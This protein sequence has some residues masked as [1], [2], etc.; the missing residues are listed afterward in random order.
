LSSAKKLL[1]LILLVMILPIVHSQSSDSVISGSTAGGT[2]DAFAGS[3]YDNDGDGVC[4]EGRDF[5]RDRNI[6]SFDTGCTIPA[7]RDFCPGTPSDETAHRSGDRAGCSD[8]Q[9][10]GFQNY[11]TLKIEKDKIRPKTVKTNWLVDQRQGIRVY[12]PITFLQNDAFLNDDEKINYRGVSVRCDSGRGVVRTEGLRDVETSDVDFSRETGGG[13]VDVSSAR[14]GVVYIEES[15][16]SVSVSDINR[17]DLNA[18]LVIRLRQQAEELVRPKDVRNYRGD[19]GIDE[20]EFECT[21]TINQ[22][23]TRIEVVDGQRVEQEGCSPIFPPETDEFLLVVPLDSVAIQAPEVFLDAGIA[24]ATAILSVTNDVKPKLRDLYGFLRNNCLRAIGIV[25][26]SK[27]FSVVPGANELADFIWF[28]PKKLQNLGIFYEGS[29]IVSGRSMCAATACPRDWCRPL[30][31][32]PGG[33]ESGSKSLADLTSTYNDKGEVVSTQPIQNSLILSTACGCVSGILAKV[34]EIEA[35]AINWRTCML[36]AKDSNEFIGECDRY[37]KEGICEFVIREVGTFDNFDLGLFS[38]FKDKGG[39][40]ETTDPLIEATQ[41]KGALDRPKGAFGDAISKGKKKSEDFAKDELEV[42][43]SSGAKGILGYKDHALAR[44]FCSLAVYKELPD[45]STLQS[46]DLNRIS[47]ESTTTSNWDI[48]EAYKGEGGRSVWGYE[49]SWMIVAGKENLRYNVYLESAG[50]ARRQLHTDVL[51]NVGDFDSDFVEITDSIEYTNLC[52]D[53]RGDARRIRCFPAGSGSQ[54]GLLE[55]F[56]FGGGINDRDKDRLPDEWE[57]RFNCDSSRTKFNTPEDERACKE[58]LSNSVDNRLDPDND[59]TDGDNTNDGSEDPDNDGINNYQEYRT[60]GHPNVASRTVDGS[61]VQSSCRAGFDDFEII[62]G[63]NIPNINSISKKFIPGETL[64][65]R[66]NNV[67]IGEG[68]TVSER[69]IKVRVDVKGPRLFS[70]D[71]FVDIPFNQASVNNNPIWNIPTGRNAPDTEVY[72]VVVQLV[73]PG[74][75]NLREDACVDSGG[76]LAEK[77]KKIIIYNPNSG[78]CID[79]DEG[80]KFN[81]AGACVDNTGVVRGDSC[82][83]NDQVNDFFCNGNNICTVRTGSCSGGNVCRN[84]A[85]VSVVAQ[86]VS[87]VSSSDGGDTTDASILDQQLAAEDEIVVEEIE[88][89]LF[90]SEL[91]DTLLVEPRELSGLLDLSSSDFVSSAVSDREVAEMEITTYLSCPTQDIV[92][93]LTKERS[94][95]VMDFIGF[96]WRGDAWYMSVLYLN[97]R[98]EALACNSRTSFGGLVSEE[99]HIRAR[100]LCSCGEPR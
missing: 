30:N 45:L 11:W 29:F 68:N 75:F 27:L 1:I 71:Q 66:L 59:N 80:V 38:R 93:F 76:V 100:E 56:G 62:G 85:C 99:A 83:G 40:G 50:G 60:N 6:N 25:F 23:R 72:E 33:K 21:A 55:E 14:T 90:E 3:A 17:T 18:D 57:V 65:V 4:N 12:Q 52:F 19:F 86:S 95:S 36:R 49:I 70:L 91:G 37:L 15:Y 42:I 53:L 67:N 97:D 74:K 94:E 34:Y 44:T 81:V 84:G 96:R 69:D 51:P 79:S 58:L 13:R 98:G 7:V 61:T 39:G 2:A 46:Y 88:P 73:V 8:N 35:I 9:L 22:C 26:T 77:T 89:L 20:I 31:W 64:S 78:S 43:G 63:D 10:T 82:N 28:G 5:Y 24:T 32:H 16:G 87:S 48:K 41:A 54:G 92:F 47:I